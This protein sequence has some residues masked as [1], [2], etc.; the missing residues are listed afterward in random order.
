MQP[1]WSRDG[2]ELYYMQASQI[3]A[4]DVARLGEDLTIGQGRPLFKLPLFLRMN[5][6][7]DLIA[8]YD[9]TPD[10]KFLVFLRASEDSNPPLV[11]VQNWREGLKKP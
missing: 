1:R 3:M 6:G 9:V 2:K 7:F 4:S 5:P 10:G 11:V 8:P